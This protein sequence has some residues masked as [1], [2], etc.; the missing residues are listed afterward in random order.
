LEDVLESFASG[1][2]CGGVIARLI[3]LPASIGGR[4]VIIARVLWRIKKSERDA[5][6]RKWREEYVVG[7]RAGLIGEFLSEPCDVEDERLKSFKLAEIGELSDQK[8]VLINV[9]MWK[10]LED[11]NAQVAHYMKV[12]DAEKRE[13]EFEVRLRILLNPAAWRLGDAQLPI[14]DSGKT[15]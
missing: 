12:T 14:H 10:S 15:F 4:A 13:F 6:L 3:A 2:D 1:I 7:D 8:V 5:F 11:F 9:G